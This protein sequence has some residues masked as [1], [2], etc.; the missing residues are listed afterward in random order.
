MNKIITKL[1]TNKK[2]MPELIIK[3]LRCGL[4]DKIYVV[5]LETTSSGDKINDY[6]L[7]N[8]VNYHKKIDANSLKDYIAG[9]NTK[10]ITEEDIFYYISNGFTC[11]ILDEMI[12]AVETRADINRS[13]SA[14]NSEPSLT[15]PKD[16]F[17]ENYQMNVGLIQ[18]RLKDENLT[19]ENFD[20]GRRTKTKIG[21]L[22]LC[23]IAEEELVENLRDKINKIDIDGLI[24]SAELSLLLEGDDK[25][26]F[27]TIIKTERPDAVC[28]A[29]LEGKVVISVDTSCFALILPAFFIDFIN[30]SADAYSKKS[31]IN[32]VKILRIVCFVISM[33]AP[34]VYIAIINYNQETIPTSLLIN[35]SIQRDGVPFPAIV[36]AIIMIILCEILRESDLRF[37]NSYGS[38]ISILGALI[39]GE[40]AVSAGIVSP[41][42]IIVIAFT[43][44]T[45]LI[46]TEY[47][48]INALRHYR[49]IFLFGAAIYGILGII[50]ASLYF[51]AN[52]NST[53]SFEKPYFF[54]IAP[55]GKEYIFKTFL[56]R[57]TVDDNKR[58][59]M[60]T[61]KNLTKQR[62]NL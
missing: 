36:E 59:E 22:Y 55:Y 24:D 11:V 51:L 2:K 53:Y 12:C 40:A 8:L 20:I 61:Q 39:L 46:F 31:N 49:F 14:P 42:M 15:G 26:S 10:V 30:P 16:A 1:K 27:P 38:A 19:I 34:A 58:S 4:F 57:R 52:I 23:D 60:L 47:E 33:L 17:T 18:K 5:F 29:L 7:K 45:S 3:E 9:P 48:L 35:F 28:K 13:I 37:P 25:T 44:I 32:F 43:F 41:I 21:V 50:F 56:K 6:I 54:P 62:S